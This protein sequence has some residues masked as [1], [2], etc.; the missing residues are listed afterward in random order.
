MPEGLDAERVSRNI[1]LHLAAE[2]GDVDE[3]KK[4]LD[5]GADVWWEVSCS[6]A[7]VCLA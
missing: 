7:T 1:A 2:A 4:L 5:E 6:D 3:A